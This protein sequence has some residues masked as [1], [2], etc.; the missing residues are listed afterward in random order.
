[1]S[2]SVGRISSWPYGAASLP[3]TSSRVPRGERRRP[4]RAADDEPGA[5]V[6][7]REQRRASRGAG[8]GDDDAG[9]PHA[10]A[11]AEGL[12]RAQR[13]DIGRRGRARRGR[14]RSAVGVA[15]GRGV[16]VAVGAGRLGRCWRGAR[17]GGRRDGRRARRGVGVGRGRRRRERELAIERRMDPVAARARPGAVA[18]PERAG[19]RR[20]HPGRDRLAAKGLRP[21]DGAE[22]TR[23][24]VDRDRRARPPAGRAIRR[25][26]RWRTRAGLQ[27]PRPRRRSREPSR[28]GGRLV[29]PD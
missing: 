20:Q 17:R 26:C 19:H 6:A 23:S 10:R 27:R 4:R 8:L 12:G 16:G 25:R 21:D 5:R 28:P 2:A 13:R 1:M 22:R 29:G 9:R 7:D 14:R 3:V 18:L 11:R 24:V 15:V